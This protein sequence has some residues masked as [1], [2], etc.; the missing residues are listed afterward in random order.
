MVFEVSP[1]DLIVKEHS[2]KSNELFIFLIVIIIFFISF[3]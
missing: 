2:N 3:I 1:F